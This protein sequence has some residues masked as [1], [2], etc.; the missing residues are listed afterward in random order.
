MNLLEVKN[1]L[2]KS[3][4]HL[5]NTVFSAKL[6]Y[7]QKFGE[8]SK[9]VKRLDEYLKI[10]DTQRTYVEQL[11]IYIATEKWDDISRL[12]NIINALSEFIK[13]DA[14]KLVAELYGTIEN[15]KET[16]H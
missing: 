13:D 14:K 8:N 2:E 3:I 1:R 16:M 9:S 4:T 7:T 5:E 12:T 6:G 10:I 15:T 11:E